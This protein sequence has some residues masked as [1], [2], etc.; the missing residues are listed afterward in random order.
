MTMSTHTFPDSTRRVPAR[1]TLVGKAK[2]S[3]VQAVH[4]FWYT[5][6]EESQG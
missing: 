5:L 3:S 2:I 6:A 4:E 1:R